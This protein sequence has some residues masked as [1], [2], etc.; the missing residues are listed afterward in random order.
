MNFEMVFKQVIQPFEEQGIQYGLIGGFALGVMG[1]L[2]STIDID[3][4]ILV[5]DLEKAEKVLSSAMYSCIYKTE[6]ISQY[7]SSIKALGNIDIIHAFRHLSK[8]MLTRV[9]KFT[10]FDQYSVKVLSPEDIIGLKVQAIAN[11]PSRHAVDF[12]DMRLIL[13]YKNMN[14]QDIDW[15]LLKDYFD[16]FNKQDLLIQL[17]DEFL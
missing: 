9:Q 7:S 1:I 10:V 3:F 12:Q 13:K 8:E 16:L 4:L 5:D 11:E 6:N 15:E 17:R 14:R 2:R